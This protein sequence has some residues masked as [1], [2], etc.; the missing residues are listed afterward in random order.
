MNIPEITL[1][2]I[3]YVPF[4]DAIQTIGAMYPK[5]EAF[6]A[7]G[8]FV[9]RSFCED[10]LEKLIAI[11]D[12]A[13]SDRAS[14][15]RVYSL[16]GAVREKETNE[17]AFSGRQ[18][19]YIMAIVSTWKKQDEEP[20]TLQWVQAGF[21]YIYTITQGS[22]INFPYNLTPDYEQAYYGEHIRRLRCVKAEYDPCDIFSFPQ[23]IKPL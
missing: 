17:T 21:K 22:Y 1:E 9:Y 12:A 23:G 7:A 19:N 14:S 20:A 10:E 5:R 18:A 2:N 4:I 15:I 6:Q 13:P 11:L 3:E 8:R 16:G